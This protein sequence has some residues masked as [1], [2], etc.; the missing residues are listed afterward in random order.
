MDAWD[1]IGADIK[2]D[3]IYSPRLRGADLGSGESCKV[4]DQS[5]GMWGNRALRYET[6]DQARAIPA[7]A[8]RSPLHSLR[9]LSEDCRL[10]YM[11]DCFIV[12]LVG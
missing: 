8:G 2:P 12:S 1:C 3:A 6:H 4:E 10:S 11:F 5:P 9:D 7:C